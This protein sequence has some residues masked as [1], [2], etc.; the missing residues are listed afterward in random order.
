MPKPNSVPVRNITISKRLSTL[1]DPQVRQA[2]AIVCNYFDDLPLMEQTVRSHMESASTIRLAMHEGR[3]VGFSVAS[4]YRRQT[5]FHPRPVNLLYQRML[6]LHPDFLFRGLG[7]RL[8]AVTMRDLF[9]WFWP[10]KRLVAV[11]RTQNP[12]VARVMNLYNLVYPQYGRPV[13]GAIRAFAESLLPLLGAESLDGKFRLI[14]TLS[15]FGGADYTDI[16]NHFY[17][18][19]GDDFE[20]L[21][22]DSAFEE[23][24]GRIL[25]SGAFILMIGYAKPMNFVRYLFH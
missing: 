17:H 16:W 5:P 20:R 24:Q 9:G 22:L 4:K 3:I 21:I 6:Y 14:G 7:I 18:R 19:R 12:I 11:C 25:N 23:K 2:A 1:S 15:A 13:P 8:L 10:F